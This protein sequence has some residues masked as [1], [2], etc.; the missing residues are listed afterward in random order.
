MSHET[1]AY[2]KF[3]YD[4]HARTC[5]SDNFLE[6]VRRTVNGQPLSDDQIGMII[7]TIQSRL[8]LGADDVLLEFACG[9]GFLSRSLF[10]TCKGYLGTDISECLI[11]VAKKHF[12][13]PPSYRFMEQGTVEYVRQEKEPERFTKALCYAG[14]QYF[15]DDAVEEIL[16]ALAGKFANIRNVFFGNIPDKARVD[17]FYQSRKPAEGELTDPCTAIGIWRTRDEL[18]RLASKTGWTVSFSTM[19]EGFHASH[20]RYDALLSR[21]E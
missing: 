18:E 7:Q 1:A 3:S 21:Q 14:L 13:I 19:P 20:Y 10:D 6:Q 15:R 2:P 4:E 5:A 11:S 16:H 8:N 9:N 12:E 17:A